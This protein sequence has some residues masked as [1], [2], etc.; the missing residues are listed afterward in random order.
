MGISGSP[1]RRMKMFR[2]VSGGIAR[3]AHSRSRRNG[4]HCISDQ[5]SLAGDRH[6]GC[7]AQQ[8]SSSLSR[9]KR[10]EEVGSQWIW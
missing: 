7:L 1:E 4:E 3:V 5:S 8:W 6:R 9:M 10:D 2:I